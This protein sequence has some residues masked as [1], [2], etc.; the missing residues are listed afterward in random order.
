MPGHTPELLSSKRMGLYLGCDQEV[1]D[2]AL[3]C[4]R[5]LAAQ[6]LRKRLGEVLLERRIVSRD[7]LRTALKA[8]RLDRLRSCSVFAGLDERELETLC[9]LVEERSI[10]AGEEFIRQDDMGDRCFVL[11]SGQAAVFQQDEDGEDIVLSMLGPGECLG[12]F[13]YFSDGRR[14]ASIRAVEDMEVLELYYTDLQ[15]AFEMTDRLAKNFLAL[16]TTRLRRTNF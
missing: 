16:V 5:Q 8:Q 12:E 14:T 4:Q 1:I 10:P 7:T 3:A 13:G 9:G 6:G 15:R 2:Q 11:A